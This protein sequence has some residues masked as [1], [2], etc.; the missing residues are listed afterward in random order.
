[1]PKKEKVTAII[2]AYNE[3]A[4]I[5]NVLRVLLSSPDLDEVIVVDDGSKDRTSEISKKIGAKTIRIEPNQGKGN[6]MKVGVKNARSE[7]V[8]FFDADLLSLTKEHISLIVQP[9]L[10]GKAAM[11]IGVRERW[12]NLPAFFIKVDPLLA[13][14]GER[15]MKRFVFENIPDKFMQGFAVETALDYYCKAN[16]LPVHYA[17]LKDLNVVVKEKKWGFIKGFKNR[18]KMIGQILKIRYQIITARK[19]FKRNV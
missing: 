5:G 12:G 6:A 8:A 18:I 14:G 16:K 15:A 1:M 7:I 4:N 11:C 3:E 13:I 19:E 10:K 9:V 17:K 2:A